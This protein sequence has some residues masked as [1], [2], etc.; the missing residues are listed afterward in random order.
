MSDEESGDIP[1]KDAPTNGTDDQEE[2]DD[3][4]DDNEEE[5]EEEG[6]LVARMA[7]E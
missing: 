5:D 1:Y 3:N 7:A 6:V 2:E 4:E